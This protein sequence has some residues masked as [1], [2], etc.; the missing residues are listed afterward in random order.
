[1][2]R[3]FTSLEKKKIFT[4]GRGELPIA[5]KWEGLIA[6]S[7]IAG[8]RINFITKP[9]NTI[10]FVNELARTLTQKTKHCADDLARV[11]P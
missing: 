8:F 9:S 11:L 5:D 2:A 3:R 4:L 7:A 6:G 1:V 10:L